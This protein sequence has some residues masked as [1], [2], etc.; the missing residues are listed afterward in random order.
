MPYNPSRLQYLFGK[1]LNNTCTVAELREFWQLM[2]ATP[3]ND[4]VATDIWQLWEATGIQQQPVDAAASGSSTYRRIQQQ[5]AQWEKEQAAP[6]NPGPFYRGNWWKYAAAAV[7]ILCMAT[8]AYI[9]F[10]GRKTPNGHPARLAD[11]HITPGGN[12]AVLTLANGSIIA[13]DEAANGAL[14]KDGAASIVKLADGQISYQEGEATGETG[15]NTIATPRGGQYQVILPDGTK[16]WLNAASSLRYPTAF[17]GKERRVTLNGEGYFEVVQ[18]ATQPFYVT[19]NGMEVKVLGT[20]FN[21]SAYDDDD[22]MHTTLLE[23]AVE[24]E[25]GADKQLLKPGQQ[26]ILHKNGNAITTRNVDTEAVVAWKDGVFTFDSDLAAI[27]RQI[28]R[29]YDIT[30]D[31][32]GNV[33]SKSFTATISRYHHISEVLTMLEYTK[34]VRFSIEGRKITV[35]PY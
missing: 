5:V 1:Y 22:S 29:W 12:K 27:M 3:E 20:H 24:V 17:T 35:E 2:E 6:Y 10:N 28:A 34:A 15:F 11:G 31:F 16:A 26:A 32:K 23:G 33:A 7:F 13:L 9:V 19:V 14:A 21:V 30:V 4:P 8:T 18:N 25:K